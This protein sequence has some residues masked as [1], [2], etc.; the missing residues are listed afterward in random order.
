MKLLLLIFIPISA[1]QG[2]R[3]IPMPPLP[4]IKDLLKPDDRGEYY[5]LLQAC[6][7][8]RQQHIIIADVRMC[9]DDCIQA[10]IT[11]YLNNVNSLASKV[12]LK[13]LQNK[14]FRMD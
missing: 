1:S 5:S 11:L 8:I 10:G 2:Y 7:I 14:N 3:Y 4:E 13:D 12:L 6:K 9:L